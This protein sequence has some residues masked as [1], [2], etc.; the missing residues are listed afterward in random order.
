M[1]HPTNRSGVV[2]GRSRRAGSPYA[3][4]TAAAM[5]G[6]SQR[7]TACPTAL[8]QKHDESTRHRICPA[9]FGGHS[10]VWTLPISRRRPR[11]DIDVALSGRRRL[12]RNSAVL[13]SASATRH[14]TCIR[15]LVASRLSAG[16]FPRS[17]C[18]ISSSQAD[19]RAGAAQR[20][21]SM[22]ESHRKGHRAATCLEMKNLDA[23]LLSRSTGFRCAGAMSSPMRPRHRHRR[24]STRI[25][26]VGS[27][28]RS[29]FR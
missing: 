28:S 10:Q 25:R 11:P 17:A 23:R 19:S 22:A 7:P 4:R 16:V 20:P 9:S 6:R 18:N 13:N 21:S 27:P 29:P 3:A 14:W 15:R 2:A 24:G 8:N 26:R 12:I 1:V 5:A